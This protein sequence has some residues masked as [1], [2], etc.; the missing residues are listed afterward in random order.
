MDDSRSA[1]LQRVAEV[2]KLA[3]IEAAIEAYEQAGM[4]GL[5]EEGAWECAVSA[6]RAVD[7]VAIVA[8]QRG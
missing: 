7:V 6:L 8:D 4:S 2:V 3:C 5:C 1:E